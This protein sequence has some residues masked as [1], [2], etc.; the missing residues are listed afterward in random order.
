MR[1][2]KPMACCKVCIGQSRTLPSWQVHNRYLDLIFTYKIFRFHWGK[3]IL[4]VFKWKWTFS[5]SGNKKSQNA[6]NIHSDNS[7]RLPLGKRGECPEPKE[8]LV[9]LWPSIYSLAPNFL[10]PQTACPCPCPFPL[11]SYLFISIS[12]SV[13]I[14]L[15][16]DLSESPHLECI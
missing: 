11:V 7:L 6:K 13:C 2:V 5:S 8:P 1:N 12:L 4:E 16:H 9:P 14:C 10:S 15:T 3:C